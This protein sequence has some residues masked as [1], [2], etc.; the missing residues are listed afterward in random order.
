MSYAAEFRQLEIINL[1]LHWG[2]VVDSQDRSG[3]TPL[4]WA[5]ESDAPRVVDKLL[6]H[7]AEVNSRDN[8]GWTALFWG[9][10][11]GAPLVLEILLQ[12]GA[13]PTIR[14]TKGLSALLVAESNN[15]KHIE[16]IR[17]VMQRLVFTFPWQDSSL[18]KLTGLEKKIFTRDWDVKPG[19]DWGM[20]NGSPYFF[21]G[22]SHEISARQLASE[23]LRCYGDMSPWTRFASCRELEPTV[24]ECLDYYINH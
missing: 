15:V 23:R 24:E 5:A 6:Q 22:Q 14:D 11:G 10:V 3:R 17:M 1:L 4:A 12:G 13:D 18:L 7:G 16:R 19:W 20:S 21:N 2:A 8:E 9:A